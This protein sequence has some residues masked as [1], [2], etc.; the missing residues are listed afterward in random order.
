M[1]K[2]IKW[3]RLYK[4]LSVILSHFHL[5]LLEKGYYRN[6]KPFH[7]YYYVSKYAFLLLYNNEGRF[8]SIDVIDRYTTIIELSYSVKVRNLSPIKYAKGKIKKGS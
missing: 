1:N 6:N 7:T 4:T 2:I 3:K 8:I 5:Y